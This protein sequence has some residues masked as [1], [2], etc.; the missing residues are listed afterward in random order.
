MVEQVLRERA[1]GAA[2]KARLGSV[3]TIDSRQCPLSVWSG[4]WADPLRMT[5]LERKADLRAS[6]PT[7]DVFVSL[8]KKPKPSD[9]RCF[10]QE[11]FRFCNL[12]NLLRPITVYAFF[13]E[14][15]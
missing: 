1:A 3:P 13:S 14:T 4:R 5:G 2:P 15:N 9:G 8:S 7:P 11:M 6:R 10:S 12:R